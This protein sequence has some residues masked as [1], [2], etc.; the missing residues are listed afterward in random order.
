[1]PGKKIEKLDIPY[2][3]IVQ[4]NL[5]EKV[6]EGT[7]GSRKREWKTHEGKTGITWENVYM[8]WTS[9]ILGYELK[10]GDFGEACIF[11]LED[12]KLCIPTDSR[13]FS[14]FVSKLCRANLNI[15]ITI[16]PYDFESDGIRR[17]GVSIEQMGFKL[18]SKFY[19]KDKGKISGFPVVNEEQKTKLKK[20]Y[21][22]VYFAEVEAFLIDQLAMLEFPKAESK[23][24]GSINQEDIEKAFSEDGVPTDLPY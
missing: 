11:Q 20:N 15:E 10:E 16:H 2:L 1:M 3:R 7:Y 13:Y 12:A 6:E 17:R 19:D 18:T 5:V 4:G 22:K 23:T 14:D 8:N 21:W 9:K 24:V